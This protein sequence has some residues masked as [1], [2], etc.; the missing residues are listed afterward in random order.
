MAVHPLAHSS[1]RANHLL[2]M[3]A[4]LALVPAQFKDAVRGVLPEPAAPLAL[5]LVGRAFLRHRKRRVD[6][7]ALPTSTKGGTLRDGAFQ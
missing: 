4:R 7:D 2:S 5:L 1:C 3:N 6:L